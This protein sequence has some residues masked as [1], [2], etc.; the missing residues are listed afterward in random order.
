M[1]KRKWLIEQRT[2][3]RNGEDPRRKVKWGA[4]KA[5]KGP[6]SKKQ[7]LDMCVK[8]CWELKTEQSMDLAIWSLWMF[9][10]KLEKQKS[11]WESFEMYC[12][13]RNEKWVEVGMWCWGKEFNFGDSTLSL[14]ADR[15]DLV[16]GRRMMTWKKTSGRQE[17]MGFQVKWINWTLKKK[18]LSSL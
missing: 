13:K 15:N 7:G 9:W 3:G 5:E 4:L 17:G 14:Y 16:E 10:T 11:E 12:T 1:V 18:A 2:L 8:H 6:V